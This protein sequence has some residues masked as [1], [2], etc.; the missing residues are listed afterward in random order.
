VQDVHDAPFPLHLAAHPEQ[1]R[2]EEL[3]ALALGEVVPDDQVDV[4]GL[5]LEGDEDDAARRGRPLAAGDE[6][7]GA[8]ELSVAALRDLLGGADTLLR[9]A[10]SQQGQRMAAQREAERGVVADDLVAFGGRDEQ[11]QLRGLRR[12]CRHVQ[13]RRRIHAQRFPQGRA[14]MSRE[15]R[16]RIGRRQGAQVAPVQAGTSREILD[17]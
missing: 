14:A 17:G 2:G 11:R 10:L 3:L 1:S 8:D 13:L 6:A 15:A 5:V 7:R 12:P 16:E 4:A 9:K